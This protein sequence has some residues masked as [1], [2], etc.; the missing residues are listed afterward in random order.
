MRDPT[1]PVSLLVAPLHLEGYTFERS[2][3]IQEF[4]P[5]PPTGDEEEDASDPD[6]ISSGPAAPTEA[7][8]TLFYFPLFIGEAASRP[9]FRFDLRWPEAVWG[10]RPYYYDLRTIDGSDYLSLIVD[11]L[12]AIDL[13][14]G[15]LE[16]YPGTFQIQ[17]PPLYDSPITI[18]ATEAPPGALMA[19]RPATTT[20]AP[21]PRNLTIS[22]HRVQLEAAVPQSALEAL[23]DAVAP[24][25]R[26]IRRVRHFGHGLHPVTVEPMVTAVPES[27]G[28]K[29]YFDAIYT[30]QLDAPE[31]GRI[32]P[33]TQRLGQLQL[34][35]RDTTQPAA[36]RY[37]IRRTGGVLRAHVQYSGNVDAVFKIAAPYFEFFTGLGLDPETARA[38][39]TPEFDLYFELLC[40]SY[41]SASGV[42]RPGDSGRLGGTSYERC[43]NLVVEQLPGSDLPTTANAAIVS[44]LPFLGDLLDV[45]EFIYSAATGRD[46]MSAEELDTIDLLALGVAAVVPILSAAETQLLRATPNTRRILDLVPEAPDLVRRGEALFSSLSAAMSL[47]NLGRH[48][49][50]NRVVSRGEPRN[51]ALAEELGQLLSA[52]RELA[53]TE[54]SE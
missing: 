52:A 47:A 53:T 28:L 14:P 19:P 13:P 35:F 34:K 11:R 29:I 31:A 43:S 7:Q 4:C 25:Q 2:S 9:S 36:Y 16:V 5:L 32:T 27:T 40:R 1:E 44:S 20:Y 6:S 45:G 54:E 10:S 26:R 18:P 12:V 33:A 46:S 41:R 22:I 49:L 37:R 50:C 8:A 24:F 15:A 39:V 51:E 3:F 21:S 17:V 42:P 23:G 38:I 48:V 30:P